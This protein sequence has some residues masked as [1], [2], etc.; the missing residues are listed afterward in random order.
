MA[1]AACLTSEGVTLPVRR[2]L[3]PCCSRHTMAVQSSTPPSS[4]ASHCERAVLTCVRIPSLG[5]TTTDDMM[6]TVQSSMLPSS[7]ANQCARCHLQSHESM[8]F[9]FL[10]QYFHFAVAHLPSSS[11]SHWMRAISACS[12]DHCHQHHSC[13]CRHSYM[14]SGLPLS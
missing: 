13:H 6:M 2:S 1:V 4:S 7:S 12:H 3:S 5:T 14:S 9:T 11:A 8:S 10:S